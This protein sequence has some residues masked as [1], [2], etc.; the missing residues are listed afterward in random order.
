MAEPSII[1]FTITVLSTRNGLWAMFRALSRSQ[2]EASIFSMRL[3][4][5]LK[6]WKRGVQERCV[7]IVIIDSNNRVTS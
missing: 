4:K 7:L 1:V 5:C 6:A 2:N 3:E